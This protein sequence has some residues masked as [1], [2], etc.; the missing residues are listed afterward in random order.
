MINYKQIYTSP[1]EIGSFSTLSGFLKNP[2][3]KS[4][5]VAEAELRKIE[6]FLL[7]QPRKKQFPKRRYVVNKFQEHMQIDLADLQKYSR[8]NDGYKY[9]L[10]ACE[11]LSKK[12]FVRKLKNKKAKTVRD[13][14]ESILNEAGFVPTLL[15]SDRGHEFKGEFKTFL[16]EKGIKQYFTSSKIAPMIERFW[17]T[18]KARLENYMTFTKRKRWCDVLLYFV[19]SY[20]RSKHSTT[21]FAPNDVTH[22]LAPVVWENTYLRGKRPPFK[23]AVFKPNDTVKVLRIKSNFEK[24]STA[25]FSEENFKIS[26]V[27][28]QKRPITYKLIDFNN[29]EIAG[30]WYP[31]ELT[32]VSRSQG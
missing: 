11:T 1:E 24:D 31:E 29:E 13:A 23:K 10:G 19:R 15:H 6:S 26:E 25:N 3:I 17:R 28:L 2:K 16:Q 30:E 8:Q 5:K 14:F 18:L 20:N 21:G 7:H 27:L 32:L 9:I 22:E 4:K 12:V